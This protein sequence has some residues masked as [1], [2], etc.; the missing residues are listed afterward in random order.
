MAVY[1]CNEPVTPRPHD[2]I[3]LLH[4]EPVTPT[5]HDLKG[6][7]PKPPMTP[8]PETP[9]TR[10]SKALWPQGSMIPSPMIPW[11]RGCKALSPQGHVTRMSPQLSPYCSHI[12]HWTPQPEEQAKN[13]LPENVVRQKMRIY[14]SEKEIMRRN[15]PQCRK[16][17]IHEMPKWPT[18]HEC[19]IT[20]L[21]WLYPMSCIMCLCH[22]YVLCH[23]TV[24]CSPLMPHPSTQLTLFDQRV[25]VTV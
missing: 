7:W 3:T 6:P 5:P 12:F 18:G 22:V 21:S 15:A 10:H 25:K 19:I 13:Q 8:R 24:Q 9:R 14:A 1:N 2:P 20:N 23:P 11:P 4:Q 17:I 16:N